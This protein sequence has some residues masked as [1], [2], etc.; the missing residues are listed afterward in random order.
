M[1]NERQTLTPNVLNKV[2]AGVVA[3]VVTLYGVM[4]I[5]AGT[6][7]LSFGI[8][9]FWWPALCVAVWLAGTA[10]GVLRKSSVTV[11]CAAV[12][13]G[14]GIMAILNWHTDLGYAQ[15]YPGFIA[16]PALASASALFFSKAK[17]TH[18]KSIILFSGLTLIFL[19]QVFSELNIYL[20]IGIAVIILGLFMF[21]NVATSRRGRWDDGDRPQRKRD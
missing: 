11:W 7:T 20:T 21:I 2:A 6:D 19:I 12:F 3:L 14:L 18:L 8:G 16:I 15:L 17:R 10:T 4:L 5:L 9:Q 13:L 1:A